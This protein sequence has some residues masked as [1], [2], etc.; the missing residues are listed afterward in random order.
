MESHDFWNTLATVAFSNEA[1]VETRFVLPLLA[2]L[3]YA[4][5]DIAAKFPVTF[6]QGKTGRPN[7]ADFVVFSGPTHSPATSLLVIEAKA[8]SEPLGEATKQQAES[9]AQWL[10][11]PIYLITNGSE[12]QIWQMQPSHA[13]EL[14]FQHNIRNLA[15]QRGKI[16]ALLSKSAITHHFSTLKLKHLKPSNIDTSA[17]LDAELSR[18]VHPRP[19]IARRL[20]LCR[21]ERGESAELTSLEVLANCPAGFVVLGRAGIGKTTMRRQFGI[22]QIYHLIASQSSKALPFDIYLPDLLLLGDSIIAHARDRLAAH[23]PALGTPGS[24]S[25]LVRRD[26]GLFLI[27]GFDRV[28]LQPHGVRFLTELATIRRDHPRCQ[29]VLFSRPSIGPAITELPTFQVAPLSYIEQYEFANSVSDDARLAMHR[30]PPFWRSVGRVPYILERI[31]NYVVAHNK[32]PKNLPAIFAEWID[33]LL[34]AD[35]PN[36]QSL[37]ARQGLL[38]LI[39]LRTV[40]EP[41]PLAALSEL[42]RTHNID[43]VEV[44]YLSRSDL[45]VCSNGRAELTHEVLADFIRAEAHAA[46]ATSQG[47]PHLRFATDSYYPIFLSA[48]AADRQQEPF[49]TSLA[50]CDLHTYL[51]T[52]EYGVSSSGVHEDSLEVNERRFLTEA[53]E[54]FETLRNRYFRNLGPLVLA[55]VSHAQGL[56][57]DKLAIAGAM[58]LNRHGVVYSF[59]RIACDQTATVT[60]LER[61]NSDEF[62]LGRNTSQIR[63]GLS[64]RQFA[65]LQFRDILTEAVRERR[66][67]GGIVWAQE[68]AWSHLEQ[69]F[70]TIDLNMPR[71]AVLDTSLPAL[72]ESLEP[73]QGQFFDCYLSNTVHASDILLDLDIITKANTSWKTLRD[74]LQSQRRYVEPL[75]FWGNDFSESECAERARAT[76]ERAVLAYREI[77]ESGLSQVS[78]LL[79]HYPQM[80]LRYHLYAHFQE[81]GYPT[82]YVTRIPVQQWNEVEVSCEV[83]PEPPA[84]AA[85]RRAGTE[86]LRQLSSLGRPTERATFYT[87]MQFFET[88]VNGERFVIDEVSSWLAEDV[89]YLFSELVSEAWSS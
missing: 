57:T 33:A 12:F 68:R 67:P 5:S 11:T 79:V 80:P 71:E 87:S 24:F 20:V 66:F 85:L 76:F 41:L 52:L 30:L 37:S 2:T 74:A 8:P 23:C 14:V 38:K 50:T 29:V 58:W 49:W 89:E 63:P 72:I 40:K 54:T 61:P 6:I 21:E 69:M 83:V 62:S 51:A 3:G 44:D 16:E 82:L 45:L 31:L 60:I 73:L 64:G 28:P 47:I 81:R 26:G 35:H 34:R 53:L 32:V 77:V 56:P 75:D 4:P 48:L 86:M 10:R 9:Y 25:D 42:L 59:E 36:F 84:R 17:Y 18:F 70:Q 19:P 39:A 22:Q 1:S 46:S 7:E 65:A 43:P 55:A 13:S 27:D 78:N 88:S 15:A